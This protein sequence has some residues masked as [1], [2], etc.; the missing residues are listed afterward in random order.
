MHMVGTWGLHVGAAIST[1]TKAWDR[2]RIRYRIGFV[3]AWPLVRHGR[4]VTHSGRVM[5]SLGDHEGVGAGVVHDLGA[6]LDGCRV[7]VQE[8]SVRPSGR[9]HQPRQCPSLAF[10]R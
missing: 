7:F 2:L 5:R 10:R 8:P 1:D 9:C 6:E 3:E 4:S